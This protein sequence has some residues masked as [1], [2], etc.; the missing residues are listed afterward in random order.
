[1]DSNWNGEPPKPIAPG[2]AT[3]DASKLTNDE[4]LL[5]L[6]EQREQDIYSHLAY[7]LHGG[8]T[9]GKSLYASWMFDLSEL[10]QAAGMAYG[11]R[12]CAE[13]FL[14]VI[15]ETRSQSASTAD[16]LGLLYRLFVQRSLSNG[17]WLALSSPVVAVLRAEAQYTTHKLAPIALPLATDAFGITPGMLRAPIAS[18]WIEYNTI[19]G[20]AGEVYDWQKPTLF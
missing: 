4:Y 17:N 12:F 15:R 14:H 16:A 1:M 8:F 2:E 13:R 19:P 3:V 9:K 10:V 5:S 20:L 18:D 7:G 6:M 11:E